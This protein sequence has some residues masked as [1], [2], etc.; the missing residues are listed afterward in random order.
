MND[1]TVALAIVG[2]VALAGVLAHGAWQARRA[3]PR[4]A[5]PSAMPPAREQQLEPVLTDAECWQRPE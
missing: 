4:R 1:L 5:T 3:G 2:G